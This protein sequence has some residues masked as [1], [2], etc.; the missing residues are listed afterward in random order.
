METEGFVGQCGLGT[1]AARWPGYPGSGHNGL[2]PDRDGP[3]S[4]L[5][6]I[7]GLRDDQSARQAG[8]A[9]FLVLKAFDF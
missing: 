7:S 9:G 4:T 5:A 1:D 8:L 2:A 3:V 6:I